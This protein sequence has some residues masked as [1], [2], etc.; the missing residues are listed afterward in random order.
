MKTNYTWDVNKRT[1]ALDLRIECEI[2]GRLLR[3]EMSHDPLVL[4]RSGSPTWMK[5]QLQDKIIQALRTEL[6]GI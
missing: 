5:Q 3:T 2:E 4:Q 1:G 6:F